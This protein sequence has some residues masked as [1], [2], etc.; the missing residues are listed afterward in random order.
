MFCFNTRHTYPGVC[1]LEYHNIKKLVIEVLLNWDIKNQR[2]KGKGVVGTILASTE[3]GEEQR[4]VTLHGHWQAYAEELNNVL[5][6]DLLQR[7]KSDRL[8]SKQKMID[9]IDLVMN[10]TYSEDITVEH[11]C[12]KVGTESSLKLGTVDQLFQ[13]RPLQEIRN[14]RHK[15]LCNDVRGGILECKECKEPF[16][17][18]DIA[19]LALAT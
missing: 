8:K 18:A 10:A 15:N 16:T 17:T 2:S 19:N 7:D 5:R 1:S 14:A 3:G 11:T 4:Q 6:N 12:H 13:Q 9:H